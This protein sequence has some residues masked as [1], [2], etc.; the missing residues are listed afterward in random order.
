MFALTNEASQAPISQ[1]YI[2]GICH[3]KRRILKL[4]MNIAIQ[5]LI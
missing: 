3:A 4:P 2:V 5:M 1:L